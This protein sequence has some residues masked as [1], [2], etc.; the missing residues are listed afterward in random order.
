MKTASL[1]LNNPT[2]WRAYFWIMVL[3][4]NIFSYLLTPSYFSS[5]HPTLFPSLYFHVSG[6]LC[7]I[8]LSYV[9]I[10]QLFFIPPP[11]ISF[12]FL[13]LLSLCV[14]SLLVSY[15]FTIIS[16]PSFSVYQLQRISRSPVDLVLFLVSVLYTC[17]NFSY[18]TSCIWQNWH[19]KM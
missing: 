13:K 9:L 3:Y 8:S 19:V 10:Q 7:L 4:G 16:S 2:G 18:S 11:P 15:S 1:T 12:T 14:L 17:S 5:F 6:L